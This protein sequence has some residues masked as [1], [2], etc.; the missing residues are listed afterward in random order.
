M[1]LTPWSRTCRRDW[2][3]TGET[4][5]GIL[6]GM[7][8]NPMSGGAK[9]TP[10]AWPGGL[11]L[12]AGKEQTGAA[13]ITQL[14]LS[15]RLVLPLRR[16]NGELAMPIVAIGDEVKRGR[17][18]ALPDGCFGVPVHAPATGRV[19]DIS[20]QAVAHPSGLKDICMTMQT[21]ARGDEKPTREI[22]NFLDMSPERLR[23]RILD[24]GIVGMGGAGFPTFTKL[25]PN[26]RQSIETLIVNAVECEPFI[27][28]D[29]RLI[30]E[31]PRQVIDGALAV[32]R[33][34]GA[35]QILI[36]VAANEPRTL[37]VLQPLVTGNMQIVCV[38]NR[39]PAGDER[40]LIHSV[41][42]REIGRETLPTQVG[43]VVHNLATVVAAYRATALSEPCLSRIITVAGAG[44]NGGFNLEVALGTPIRDLLAFCGLTFT[45]GTAVFM[46]GPMMG[47]EVSDLDAPVGKTSRCL[48]VRPPRQRPSPKACIRCGDCADVCPLRL[49][50]QSLYWHARAGEFE[51]IVKLNL[52]DCIECGCCTYVC[53]SRI[54]LVDYFRFAKAEIRAARLQRETAD[55]ARQRFQTRAA[56]VA[57]GRHEEETKRAQ[58]RTTRDRVGAQASRKAAMEAALQRAKAK[59]AREEAKGD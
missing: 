4:A 30:H 56:R 57:R 48:L 33:A 54:P 22:S 34:A 49:S 2:P 16:H 29:Q 21:S 9:P 13:E 27:A 37:A 18:V 14:P 41:S 32:A 50:P 43:I 3:G 28:C 19:V 47:F 12:A 20:A 35:K 38:P 52:F 58:R 44:V 36:A 26:P 51:P 10:A 23:K 17:P 39:Y 31:R 1:A 46:G 8:R 55:H 59:R 6:A 15:P 11:Q 7:G 42:G 24:A 45:Q 40:L 53:P 25:K 5:K